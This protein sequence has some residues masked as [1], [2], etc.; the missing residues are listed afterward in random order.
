[1]IKGFVDASFALGNTE[2]LE[3]ALRCARFLRKKA[4][5]T[6]GRIKRNLKPGKTQIPGFLDDYAYLADAW[7][8]LYQAT[9][10]K[11]WLEEAM[12]IISIAI[13][14]FEEPS[15]GLFFYSPAEQTQLSVRKRII[16][17]NVLPSPSAVIAKVM[18]TAGIYSEN[19]DL[20]SRSDMLCQIAIPGLI[21]GGPY[22][23][24]WSS[25]MLNQFTGYKELTIS[26]PAASEWIY[27]LQKQYLPDV[28][29]CGEGLFIDLPVKF[30]DNPAGRNCAVICKAKECSLPIYSYNELLE[31]ITSKNQV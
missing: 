12:K 4:F 1:M 11:S 31:M 10:E 6:D 19:T 17:D 21:T 20:L 7:I 5:C 13:Q 24:G 25:L 9:L 26:G 16:Q 28:L 14:L 23:S 15:T 8:S 22:M 27:K 3:Y 2:Y 29:I 18:Q 30:K